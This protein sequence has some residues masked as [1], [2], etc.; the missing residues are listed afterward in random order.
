MKKKKD[1]RRFVLEHSTLASYLNVS[2]DK[3]RIIGVNNLEF[4]LDNNLFV[5][6]FLLKG[7]N[8]QEFKES[9]SSFMK[10]FSTMMNFINS[11]NRRGDLS[12]RSAENM[13]LFK[14]QKGFLLGHSKSLKGGSGIGKIFGRDLLNAT[15]EIID[16]NIDDPEAYMFIPF[17]KEGIGCDRIS[18]MVCSILK[19]DFASYTER[20]LKELNFKNIKSYR[21]GNRNF[22]LASL[23]WDDK[24]PLLFT[25]SSFLRKLPGN[26]DWEDMIDYYSFHNSF[27]R[28]ISM[29][30]SEYIGQEKFRNKKNIDKKVFKTV[31]VNN[32]NLLKEAISELQVLYPVDIRIKQD[33]R[34]VVKNNPIDLRLK[35]NG[36]NYEIEV[37]N[38][39]CSK[40]K[41][42]IED[43]KIWGKLYQDRSPLHE[44]FA[45][46]FF[47]AI[48]ESYC[49]ANNIDVSVEYETGRG[50]VDFRFA[51]GRNRRIIV[52]MKL[53][54]SSQIV[55]GYKTQLKEYIKSEKPHYSVY[56]VVKVLRDHSSYIPVNSIEKYEKY[57]SE[58]KREDK[59]ISNLVKEHENNP[60]KNTDLVIVSAYPM[61]SA[62][63][64]GKYK[65]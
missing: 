64:L 61:L 11:S 33:V 26:Y 38:R 25:P 65:K 50:P 44:E 28:Q 59:R 12:W 53:S 19:E 8:I 63:V 24:T 4:P 40:Y 21:I 6:L 37:V 55:N 39:I 45:Q 27:R 15:K 20:I 52:E 5:D 41:E 32:P 22:N 31:L 23:P 17:L 60:L 48:A 58:I 18:D 7:S 13:A 35:K 9:Y 34:K 49:D 36:E 56:L 29:A 14:E 30:L 54:V 1:E 43:R 42:M 2:S 62:S 57:E 16:L 3:L 47:Y 46:A 51:N 10:Y